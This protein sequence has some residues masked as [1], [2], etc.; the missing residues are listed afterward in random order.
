MHITILT[1]IWNGH[2]SP[3]KKSLFGKKCFLEAYFPCWR[4]IV[5]Q[6]LA[7]YFDYLS[8]MPSFSDLTLWQTYSHSHAN[9]CSKRTAYLLKNGHIF[10]KDVLLKLNFQDEGHLRA[11]CLFFIL[12][13]CLKSVLSPYFSC[14]IRMHIS[15]ITGVRKGHIF[16]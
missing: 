8:Y 13:L 12:S 9:S 1:S 5:S 11:N 4:S 10:I 16:W 2:I 15:I 14:G 6:N 3:K 7:L